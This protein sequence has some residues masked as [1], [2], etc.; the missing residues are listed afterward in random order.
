MIYLPMRTP[1][2]EVHL[3][4][5]LTLPQSLHPPALFAPELCHAFMAWSRLRFVA[6]D[7]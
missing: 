2:V 7:W 4:P 6:G 1:E 5:P 3:I